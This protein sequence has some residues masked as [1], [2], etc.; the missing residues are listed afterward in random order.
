[1]GFDWAV[2]GSVET[3]SLRIAAYNLDGEDLRA[4]GDHSFFRALFVSAIA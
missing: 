3:T 1:M 4:R 2:D